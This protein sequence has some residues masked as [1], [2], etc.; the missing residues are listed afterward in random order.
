MTAQQAKTGLSKFRESWGINVNTALLG[1]L[2]F[3]FTTMKASIATNTT[4]IGIHASILATDS[5]E[6][7]DLK[8]KINRAE[9]MI[10]DIYLNHS[11][12]NTHH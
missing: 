9:G 3:E 6:I 4:N 10:G 11:D 2:M 5:T 1:I 7:G 12:F 8:E